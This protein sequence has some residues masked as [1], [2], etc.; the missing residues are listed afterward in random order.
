MNCS[1][2]L[3]ERK[4]KFVKLFALNYLLSCN[5]SHWQT[6]KPVTCKQTDGFWAFQQ[7]L[8]KKHDLKRKKV[9]LLNLWSRTV[10]FKSQPLLQAKTAL[11]EP[12][13]WVQ[14]AHSASLRL[15][16][17]PQT[18]CKLQEALTCLSSTHGKVSDLVRTWA[19]EEAFLP[20]QQ[21]RASAQDRNPPTRQGRRHTHTPPRLS[22]PS[23]NISSLFLSAWIPDLKS[24]FIKPI[25]C[26]SCFPILCIHWLRYSN[27]QSCFQRFSTL[28]F[29]SVL[30]PLT[31]HL[32]KTF[33]SPPTQNETKQFEVALST[34]RLRRSGLWWGPAA[35]CSLTRGVTRM[36]F[37]IWKTV[38]KS[39]ENVSCLSARA[40]GFSAAQQRAY[41]LGKEIAI[42][43]KLCHKLDHVDAGWAQ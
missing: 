25:D 15:R 32:L 1:W 7:I 23:R 17:K 36:Q 12:T 31:L 34:G 42:T 43:R 28:R 33:S 4:N 14:R 2:I 10:L 35:G 22:P 5:Y 40:G 8:Q 27:L 26:T 41:Q 3:H 18:S 16:T 24:N 19:P 6:G 39:G 29:L 38:H 11:G 37:M 9:F 21:Y 20:L 30:A 13:P